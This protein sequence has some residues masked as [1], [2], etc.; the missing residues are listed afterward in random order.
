MS[1]ALIHI[2]NMP[3]DG[4]RELIKAKF[5]PFTK[6]PWIDYNKGETQAWVRL[7]E[8]NTAK[9]VLDKVLAAN[10]G[11]LQI[12]ST[13]VEPRV[14]EGEEELKFWKEANE[15][16]AEQRTKKRDGGGRQNK[17][18]GRGG[19][20]RR[21]GRNG[22][23]GD[24]RKRNDRNGGTRDEDG[25]SNGSGDEQEQTSKRAKKLETDFANDD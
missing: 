12:N 14:V 4:T 21:G 9:D 20:D 25:D 2:K 22:R 7:N 16:R 17:R 8:A 23:F 6:L 10:G 5:S 15:K 18:G 24:K 1:G 19:G 13:E 11:K 3:E